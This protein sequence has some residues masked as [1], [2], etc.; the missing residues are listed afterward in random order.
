MYPPDANNP[1]W[2][3]TVSTQVSVS[4]YYNWDIGKGTHIPGLGEI[5]DETMGDL[6]KK[7]LAK[8]FAMYGS[9]DYGTENY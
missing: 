6:M 7:G 8:E 5:S 9:S 3:A 1:N 4:D 2:H